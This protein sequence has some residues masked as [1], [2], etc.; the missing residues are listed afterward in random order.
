MSCMP[1]G[2]VEKQKQKKALAA[3]ICLYDLQLFWLTESKGKTTDCPCR[4]T[5]LQT[6][7]KVRMYITASITLKEELMLSLIP[8][9]FFFTHNLS[10][11]RT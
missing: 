1:L 10:N 6:D 3:V 2:N 8:T 7:S 11:M 4:N 5:L 9:L